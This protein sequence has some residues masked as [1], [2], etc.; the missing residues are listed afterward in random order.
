MQARLNE[1]FVAR[2]PIVKPPFIRSVIALIIFPLMGI[3]ALVFCFISN[4]YS[5]KKNIQKA[6]EFAKMARITANIAIGLA[7]FFFLAVFLLLLVPAF[8]TVLTA[9]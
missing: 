6:E 5:D 8:L 1:S 3:L 4:D 7:I 9:P 2:A